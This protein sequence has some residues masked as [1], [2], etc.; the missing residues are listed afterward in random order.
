M[1]SKNNVALITGGAKRIG[2]KI[3]C[4]LASKG[5]DIAIS[6]NNSKG[7]AQNLAKKITNDFK[8][9]CEIFKCDL[10]NGK[11][12][13]L[14]IDDVLEKFPNLN[15]LI[16]NASVFKQSKFLDE[17]GLEQLQENLNVHF[18]APLVLMQKF[19]LNVK[20]NNLPNAQI[21]NLLDKNINRFETRY[22]YYI[23]TK[24]NLA[25]LTKMLAV[26][27]APQIRVNGIGPGF[28][29]DA[30]DNSASQDEVQKIIKK[31]PLEKK[32]D[33]E[34]I[35]QTV[36]YLLENDFINGQIINVDGGASLNHA[37]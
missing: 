24:K 34:N 25:N 21:I 11:E 20:Q 7:E 37:G 22:F 18:L 9:K 8:V 31:I 16:N 28:I 33:V 23:L 26:E 32:G 15:L 36:G 10:A 2:S 29:L 3:A 27:L 4:F 35:C 19:A 30:I 5:F 13:E 12:V 6:Y 17:D 1:S 14:L